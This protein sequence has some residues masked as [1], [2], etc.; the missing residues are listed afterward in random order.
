VKFVASSG[1]ELGHLGLHNYLT[2]NATFARDAF[3]W[4]HLGANIGTSTGDTGMTPSDDRL[5]DAPLRVFAP[6]G[7]DKIRQS[8]AAQ[9][10]GEAATI[11]QA[12]GRFISFIGANA[13]FHNPGDLWPDAVDIQA[14][15]RFARA[16]ADLTLSL[17]N[18]PAV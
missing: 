7:L 6:H 17:A 12:G 5:R 9:V 10:N 18:T 8:Q 4:V 11:S 15:A 3:A 1:H 16:V 14:V 13:W 2:R